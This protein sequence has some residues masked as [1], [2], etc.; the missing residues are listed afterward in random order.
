MLIFPVVPSHHPYQGFYSECRGEDRHAPINV[1]RRRTVTT[2]DGPV[3]F[4]FLQSTTT[5]FN[6]E[7]TM[8]NTRRSKSQYTAQLSAVH[9]RGT[10]GGMSM[11]PFRILRITYR[12]INCVG[13]T[14]GTGGW[15]HHG[16]REDP[17]SSP[18]PCSVMREV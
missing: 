18:R 5:D 1:Y 12:C 2:F 3:I 7:V 15:P 16:G 14:T 17:C 4:V 13:H 8:R 11:L 9:A 6:T 10:T